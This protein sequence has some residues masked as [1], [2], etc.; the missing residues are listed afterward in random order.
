M[1]LTTT[2][3]IVGAGAIGLAIGC[4]LLNAGIDFIIVEKG[5]PGMGTTCN[6]A[7]VLHSG[8][9]YALTD[10]HLAGLCSKAK[11]YIETKVKFTVTNTNDAYYLI[12]DS[13]GEAYAQ[14]L[15]KGCMELGIP[16]RTITKD[17]VRRCEPKIRH[18]VIGALA[19]P[20]YVMDPF[21]LIYAYEEHIHNHGALLLRNSQLS[22]ARW[23]RDYWTLVIENNSSH[24]KT[25]ITCSVVIVASGAWTSEVL[26][27]FGV[28]MTLQYINGSMFV[29]PERLVSR[30]VCL[31]SPP[32]SYDSVI[33]CYEN[34]LIGSTWK[35][36]ATPEPCPPAEGDFEEAL[37][38]LCNYVSIPSRRTITHGYSGVRTILGGDFNAPQPISR[39]MRRNFHVLDHDGLHGTRNLL[40]VFGG[41][42]TIHNLMALEAVKLVRKKL[43]LSPEIGAAVNELIRP[44][45][46][47]S[48][49][50]ASPARPGLMTN[51]SST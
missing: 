30:V 27:Q 10:P 22:E 9:R 2:V 23:G 46:K 43:G 28:D 17:E 45:E 48:M 51:P 39:A 16:V 33:P 40:S 15:I 12:T 49:H 31:C 50:L 38:N 36:Q 32:S 19:V 20:D 35:Q 4:A 7:G 26:E 42:L 34:T 21:L 24:S 11:E 25:N 14:N 37:D 5:R 29:F 6:S 47:T 13:M 3:T 8:A 41:K 44:N 18:G 1:E